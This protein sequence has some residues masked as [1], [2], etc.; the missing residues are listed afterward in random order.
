MIR[1]NALA[2]SGLLNTKIGGESVK[3]YQPEGYYSDK[4]GRQ[5]MQSEGAE[6]YRRGVYTYWRRTTPYPSFQ[7]FDAPSRE[8]CTVSRPRTNTPMQALVLLND[9]TFVEAAAASALMSTIPPMKMP[10]AGD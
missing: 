2:A 4:V 8:V 6:L 3:P 5:W 10:S 7:I 9:P 1:D